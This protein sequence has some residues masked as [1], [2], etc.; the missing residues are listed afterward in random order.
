[1]GVDKS[2]KVMLIF[3]GIIQIILFGYLLTEY[4]LRK[5]S[6]VGLLGLSLPVGL[7]LLTLLIF[8]FSVIGFKIT[9][10]HV[11]LVS[12]SLLLILLIFKRSSKKTRVPAIKFDKIDL[13][14]ITIISAFLIISLVIA[15]YKPVSAWDALALYD[16]RAKV[17]AKEGF[18]IQIAR[19]IYYFAHYPLLTSLGH[20]FVYLWGSSNPQFLYPLFFISMALVLFNSIKKETST[21]VSLIA[22]LLFVTNPEY[23]YHSTIAYTNLPYAFFVVSGLIYFYRFLKTDKIGFLTVSSLLI[24]LS[25]WVRSGEPFWLVPLGF[26]LIYS[27]V[28]RN[29]KTITIYSIIFLAIQQPWRIYQGMLFGSG[30]STIGQINI[31]FQYT[32]KTP[33]IKRL[34]E[35]VVFTW[36]NI[37]AKWGPVFYLFILSIL[38][39]AKALLKNGRYLLLLILIAN[40]ILLIGGT[41]IFSQTFLDWEKIPDSA[42]RML[43][44]S[45]L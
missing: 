36:N 22:V 9:S 28:K 20:T 40:Y 7:G 32:I 8:Y 15:I 14:L 30:Y 3:I 41:Y 42:R 16:F 17:I 6:T 39:E 23:F 25:T 37:F 11:F 10:G 35:V 18:F 2:K 1:M 33:D 21:K 5:E 38:L 44:F 27:L 19:D 45:S 13:L 31:A 29:F 24:G 43:C 4:I 26:L 12:T 34:L